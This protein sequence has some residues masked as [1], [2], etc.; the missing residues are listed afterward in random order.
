M[1]AHIFT[2]LERRLVMKVKKNVEFLMRWIVFGTLIFLTPLIAQNTLTS[3]KTGKDGEKSWVLLHFERSASWVGI[4]KSIE[5]IVSLYFE[6]NSEN[7]DQT[8]YIIEG[9]NDA[10]LFIRQVSQN[11]LIFRAEIQCD[12]NVPLAAIKMNSHLIIAINDLRFMEGKMSLSPKAFNLQSNNLINVSSIKNENEMTA[13]LHF[14]EYPRIMG[15]IRPSSNVAALLLEGAEI[16]YSVIREYT[17]DLS[18][19]KSIKLFEQDEPFQIMKPV[20]F[21]NENISFSIVPKY[22]QIFIQAKTSGPSG[23]YS[24]ET[25]LADSEAEEQDEKAI[26]QLLSETTDSD[27]QISDVTDFAVSGS[28]GQDQT[29]ILKEIGTA[30]A[31]IDASTLDDQ[32]LKPDVE[33]DNMQER[34]DIDPIPWDRI[35]GFNI[36]ATPVKDALRTLAISNDLNM[37]IDEGVEGEVTMNLENVTL[38]QALDKI[39][40]TNDCEYISEQGIITVKPIKVKYSGG[41]YTKVYRLK[42]A[43]AVNVANV[44]KRIVSNDSLVQVFHP[45]FLNF[46]EA[47]EAR[48]AS[49]KVAVQGI[50]RSSTLV[51]TDRPEK[52]VEVDRII[53]ELDKPPVQFMIASKLVETSPQNTS[54]LGINW[55]KTITAVLQ[56]EDLLDAGQAVEYSLLNDEPDGGG[57]FKMG[58]LSIGKFDAVLDFLKEKTDTKLISNPRILA[59]DNE[60][61][62]ISVGETVPVPVLQRGMG[63]QGDMITFDYKEVNIQLNVTPHLARDGKITMYVNP[64]I[65]EITGWVV[66]GDQNQQAPITSKRL[67]NSIVTVKNGETIVI[68]GLIKNQKIKTIKK[69]WLLGNIPLIGKLFQHEQFEDKQTDL[70]IFIT[71]TVIETG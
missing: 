22:D 6:A 44:V 64:I 66:A 26:D 23:Y 3:V 20:I 48:R 24:E 54:Q 5:N 55:D 33:S 31:D 61:A 45:E 53:K 67:V 47:G 34:R 8:N 56:N 69:V 21:F 19:I 65:E 49:N 39:V 1:G 17:Y 59:M 42:Y 46:V 40:Y 2:L 43:D 38:R 63:G 10:N 16:E 62:S 7:F 4:S 41:S 60:E 71:P 51:V 12:E 32:L 18:S 9:Q 15:Y 30:P 58:H 50:R 36:R 11:P 28:G 27:S 25:S 14:D 68:G 35:V 52:M 29:E 13:T 70:M 37:V 57:Q